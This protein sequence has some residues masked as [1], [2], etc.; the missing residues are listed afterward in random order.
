MD[1]QQGIEFVLYKIFL[2]ERLIDKVLKTKKM[3]ILGYPS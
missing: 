2:T 3:M 1:I